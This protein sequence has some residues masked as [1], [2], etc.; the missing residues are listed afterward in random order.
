LRSLVDRLLETWDTARPRR[1]ISLVCRDGLMHDESVALA[2]YTGVAKMAQTLQ[3][4]MSAD[5]IDAT[6]ATPQPWPTR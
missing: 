6:W 3:S 5:R 2:I 4:W 1:L